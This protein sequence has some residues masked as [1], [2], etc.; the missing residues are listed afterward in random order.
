MHSSGYSSEAI[1]QRTREAMLKVRDGEAVYERDSVLFDEVHLSF[2]LLAALLRTAVASDGHLSVLD[3]GGALGSSYFQ[4]RGFLGPVRELEWL[5]VEQP[6]HVACGRRDFQTPQLRFYESVEECLLH[7]CPTAL[8][9]SS[10]LQYL[11]DPYQTL[12][13]LLGQQLRCV[14]IDRTG[15]LRSGRERLA[16]Q[17]T[18]S[19]IYSAT[20]PIWFFS[21]ETMLAAIDAAGYNLVCDFDALDHL[22]PEG[23]EAYYKG[24]CFER[25]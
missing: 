20:Y 9:L 22:S 11:P 21:E 14:V 13:R 17:H 3:F 1:L 7:H 15:F 2:P 24:F 5:V 6:G 18:P 4:C 16:V 23:E 12:S 8:L 19:S 25:R 10:V